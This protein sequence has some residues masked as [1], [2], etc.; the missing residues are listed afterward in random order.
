MLR[1]AVDNPTIKPLASPILG[2]EGHRMEFRYGPKKLSPAPNASGYGCL[3]DSS[4]KTPGRI[5]CTCHLRSLFE[6]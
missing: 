1:K 5:I 4:D 3:W 2:R 6:G